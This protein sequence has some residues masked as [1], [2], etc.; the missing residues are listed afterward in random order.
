MFIPASILGN[1]T[2]LAL[3]TLLLGTS[4]E[5]KIPIT[6]ILEDA[7]ASLIARSKGSDP[8]KIS[9][10]LNVGDGLMG[11]LL[12]I[13][14][15][16]T[17]NAKHID[18]DPAIVRPGRM[19]SALNFKLLERE[20]AASVYKNIIGSESKEITKSMSLAEVYR[21]MRQDGWTPKRD[22]FKA[23]PDDDTPVFAEGNYV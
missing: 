3:A 5:H 8:A 9:D 18:I 20:H 16:A 1:I 4:R 12:D 14:I 19:C 6:L 22:Y 11:E 2:A 21:L 10:L 7:D 23:L 15:I 13:R 17:T